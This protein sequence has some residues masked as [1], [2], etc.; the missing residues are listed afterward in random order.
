M[1]TLQI[2]LDQKQY[3]KLLAATRPSIIKSE[4]E[5]DRLLSCIEDL[6]RKGENNLSAE[7][8]TLL[9]LLVNLVHDYEQRQ[10][11]TPAIPPHQIVGY[12][13]EQQGQEPSALLPILGTKSRVSEL[14]SG[15][16]SI[17]KEQAKKL[18]A[19]F[20]KSVDLFI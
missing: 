13:L 20:K 19:F 5:N 14:L 12:L 9:E 15:K 6:M 3:G 16:R 10:Y 8:G 7:E 4:A 17:S 2:D 11:P 18:S 1:S